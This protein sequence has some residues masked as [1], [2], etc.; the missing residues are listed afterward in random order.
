MKDT[1]IISLVLLG[2]DEG[3]WPNGETKLIPRQFEAKS[4]D[5]FRLTATAD[6]LEKILA[7][8]GWAIRGLIW[9]TDDMAHFEGAAIH[10]R[11]EIRRED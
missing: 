7:D 2:A 3:R 8:N 6:E 9:E 1:W 11:F 4:R 10:S 5:L